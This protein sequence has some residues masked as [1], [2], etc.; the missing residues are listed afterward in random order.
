[1]D[2][3]SFP[4]GRFS[5]NR[6]TSRSGLSSRE[7]MRTVFL[8]M[9]F[10]GCHRV[11]VGAA[12]GAGAPVVALAGAQHD[13]GAHVVVPGAPELLGHVVVTGE[14]IPLERLVHIGASDLLRQNA[15]AQ[16]QLAHDGANGFRGRLRGVHPEL[17]RELPPPA[18]SPFGR[19]HQDIAIDK[20]HPSRPGSTRSW[21]SSRCH[22]T[23]SVT[24]EK[25]L[26]SASFSSRAAMAGP[27]ACSSERGSSSKIVTRTL[28]GASVRDSGASPRHSRQSP[29]RRALYVRIIIYPL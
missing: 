25:V 19:I 26:R 15:A 18:F 8:A 23:G 6:W 29:R 4:S 3:N 27:R 17:A 22:L 20:H 12:V 11:H 16:H 14:A 7:V 2:L 10:W 21:R 28:N 9:V 5:K 24:V 13:P 1:M